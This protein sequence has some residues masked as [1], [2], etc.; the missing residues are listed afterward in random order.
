MITYN[1]VL[2]NIID[3][4]ADDQPY[5]SPR[6]SQRMAEHGAL[7]K[8]IWNWLKND[9]F[10]IE[11]QPPVNE[12]DFHLS[13]INAYGLDMDIGILKLKKFDRVRSSTN[14]IPP[15]EILKTFKKI[16]PTELEQQKVI[17]GLHR[18]LLKFGIDHTIEHDLSKILIFEEIYAENVTRIRLM[19]MVKQVRNVVLYVRSVF[20][21]KFGNISESKSSTDYGMYS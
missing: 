2:K 12:I 15:D 6:A 9:G 21:E 13:I 4:L 19:D 14:V 1:I 11:K 7:E 17:Q 5:I 20:F 3:E 8:R 18:E 16:N 10:N